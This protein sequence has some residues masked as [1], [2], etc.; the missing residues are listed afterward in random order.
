MHSLGFCASVALL[1]SPLPAAAQS[2]PPPPSA[3]QASPPAEA[4]KP[5]P[6]R[7]QKAFGLPDWLKL[8][9][10]QRT[11]FESLNGQFRTGS[12]LDSSDDQWALRTTL[13]ADVTLDHFIATGE[14]WDARQLN[15]DEGSSVNT[16]IVN[17]AEIVQLWAGFK[18]EGVFSEGD[19]G[20]VLLGRHTM[21]L[22]NRRLVAR[23]AYRNTTN[24]F[25]GV[26]A[27]WES[28][29]GS[30]LQAFYTLPTNRLP[31]DLDAMLD[32][33]VE[34][35]EEYDEVKFWGLYSRFD[36]ALGPVAAEL[37]YLGLDEEDSPDLATSNR[38]LSTV[39]TRI[40][41]EPD[42]QFPTFEV[43]AAFQFGDSRSSSSSTT[44]LDHS[45]YFVH[46]QGGRKF[47]ATWSPKALL[48][49]DYA[50]GDDDPT[51]DENNRFDTLFGA[52]RWEFGPTGILGVIARSNVMSPGG[53]V[54]LNPTTAL[55]LMM[56]YRSIYLASDTDAW[57]PGGVVDP[58]G[59]SG[60]HVGELSELSLQWQA[61]PGNWTLEIGGAYLANGSFLDDAPNAS[62]NGDTLYGYVQSSISI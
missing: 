36:D 33:E 12:S 20:S 18:S 11:R 53:H 7:L 50:S 26:N 39:G 57:V 49:F 55:T 51:D 21:D 34:F 5:E 45:A 22:G 32:N 3:P 44:D 23:N 48:Q 1:V 31:S 37:Y 30:S 62:G 17:A 25:L 19:E 52:R 59:N 43:E 47:D 15:A 9:A 46:A 8:T 29:S 24:T 35:D 16:T 27:R 10:T 56:G 58:T 54:Y 28:D 13:R 41:D 4:R 42:N 6:W 60:D 2:N 38:V 40:V 61:L 14:F